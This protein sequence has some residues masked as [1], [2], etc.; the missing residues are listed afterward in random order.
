M[1]MNRRSFLAAL[2]ASAS[3]PSAWAAAPGFPPPDDQTIEQ[4][5]LYLLGRILVLRQGHGDR[6]GA[7][8]AYKPLGAAD[9]VNP[10]FDAAYLEAWFTARSC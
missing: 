9:F 2:A 7:G 6:G 4:A 1:P 10:N 3:F 5:Y 8:F